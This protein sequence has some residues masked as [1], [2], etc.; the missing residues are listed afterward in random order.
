MQ[1]AFHSLRVVPAHMHILK[2]SHI[3]SFVIRRIR[4]LGHCYCSYWRIVEK[5]PYG[6]FLEYIHRQ[7]SSKGSCPFVVSTACKIWVH[8]ITYENLATY[9]IFPLLV[10]LGFIN[11]ARARLW[12]QYFR[13]RECHYMIKNVFSLRCQPPK[14]FNIETSSWPTKMVCN[15]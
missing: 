12:K 9:F 5:K 2:S 10:S 13:C 14:D 1:N 8:R 15:I 4:T 6:D 3:L 11:V 7:H